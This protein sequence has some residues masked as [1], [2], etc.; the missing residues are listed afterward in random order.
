MGMSPPRRSVLVVDDDEDL[1]ELVGEAL[2]DKGIA[3]HF[4]A[5]GRQAIE[6]LRRHEESPCVILLDLR[7]PVMDG[8]EFLR[9]RDS[10]PVLSRVPVLVSTS[11][12]NCGDLARHHHLAGFLP[13]PVALDELSVAIDACG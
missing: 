8:R 10:D 7:M 13:K 6:W 9:V 3:V 11:E 1:R 4:A 5:N 2:V 12:P